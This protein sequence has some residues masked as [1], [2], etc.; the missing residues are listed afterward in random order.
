MCLA[1]HCQDKLIQNRQTALE[2]HKDGFAIPIR[3]VGVL[4]CTASIL[5]DQ[6]QELASLTEIQ[7]RSFI[8]MSHKY[9]SAQRN[10]ALIV[11]YWGVSR[12]LAAGEAESTGGGGG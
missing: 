7:M 12:Q 8:C 4:D 10:S 5:M 11:L 2:A 6:H 3:R 1:S 9:P